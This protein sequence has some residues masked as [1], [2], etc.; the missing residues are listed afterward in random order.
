MSPLLGTVLVVLS[1]KSYVT[2]AEG[3]RHSTGYFLSELVVPAQHLEAAGIALTFATPGGVAPAMDVVSDDAKWF[4]NDTTQLEAARTFVAVH[5]SPDSIVNLD[6]L[7]EEDLSQFSGILFPGGHAPMEDLLHD[8][9]VA[10]ALQYFHQEGRPTGLIC[11]GPAALLATEPFLYAGYR[12]TSFSTAEESQEEQAGHLD[13]TMPFYLDQALAA[14]GAHVE[15]GAPW[16]SQAV[17]DR[18]LITGRNPFSDHAFADLFLEAL[19]EQALDNAKAISYAGRLQPGAKTTVMPLPAEGGYRT[20]WVGGRR[21]GVT[22][23]VSR[24]EPHVALTVETFASRGLLGYVVFATPDAE[25][26]EMVW[27][28]RAAAELAFAA[29]EGQAV[30]ADAGSF[31]TALLFKEKT[32]P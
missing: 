21:D 19:A 9:G 11:H 13:G 14:L 18:E 10:R 3:N 5:L 6:Q 28:D 12:M 8:A 27:T 32:Q 22:N 29:P 1:A 7:D 23:F 20:I 17:R 24:L 15:V 30:A 26:A 25:I 31:M 2:T 16:A 4:G